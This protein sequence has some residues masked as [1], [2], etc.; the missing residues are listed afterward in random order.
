MSDAEFN[1]PT[2]PDPVKVE[3]WAGQV[4]TLIA[5][6]AG[7]GLVGG[8][9]AGVSAQQIANVLTAVLTLGGLAAGAWASFSSWRQKAAAEKAAREGAVAAAVASATLSANAGQAIPVTVTVTPPGQEN[10]A[11]K[12]SP[13]EVAVAQTVPADVQPR[14]ASVTVKT[15]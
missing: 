8:A 4:R 13:A 14:P 1:F 12:V 2:P 11:T 15:A 10:V 9:W 7:A 6:L 5:L 3:Q